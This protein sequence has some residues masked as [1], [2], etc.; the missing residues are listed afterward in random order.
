MKC[1][2]CVSVYIRE[3]STEEAREHS[4]WIR[5]QVDAGRVIAVG[6]RDDLQGGVVVLNGDDAASLI[7]QDPF[8]AAGVADYTV[9]VFTGAGE[10][11]TSLG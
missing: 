11:L 1:T 4:A 9:T 10:A 5:G 8:V 7:K 6:R 2:L 3:A